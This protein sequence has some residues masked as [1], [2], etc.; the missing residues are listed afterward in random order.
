MGMAMGVN[1][2]AGFAYNTEMAN[3]VVSA[4][5]VYHKSTDGKYLTQHLK[6]N[7]TYDEQQRLTKKEVLKWNGAAGKWEQSHCLIYVYDLAGY[8]V[9]YAMWNG[10]QGGY[11]AAI[12]RQS[13]RDLQNGAVAVA[14][15][16]R[17]KADESWEVETNTVLLSAGTPLF[18]AAEL[19]F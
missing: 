1:G 6:Y 14:Q 12:A 4:K 17:D 9:E 13:Y 16:R 10:K 19:N 8:S 15:Y 18:A 7:Y 2:E 3:G 11:D 5:T